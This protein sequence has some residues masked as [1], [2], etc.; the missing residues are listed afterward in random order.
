MHSGHAHQK[1]VDTEKGSGD[2]NNH[3]TTPSHF[4]ASYKH[5]AVG[6]PCYMAPELHMDKGCDH[7][8]DFWSLGVVLFE[9]LFGHQPFDP[10]DETVAKAQVLSIYAE[11][12]CSSF[13]PQPQDIDP[14][15]PVSNEAI[16]LLKHLLC[17][18]EY[19]IHSFS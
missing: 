19:R 13:L 11:G 18:P 7:C 4:H 12:D 14:E 16:D 3:H 9:M 10:R 17:R 8:A 1:H 6:T 5:T 15:F 2:A